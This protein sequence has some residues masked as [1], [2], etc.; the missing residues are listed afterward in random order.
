M[1]SLFG[2]SPAEILFARQKEQEQMQMLKNQQI[3][4]QGGQF[5]VFAPLYQAGLKF[6]DIGA[7]AMRQGLFPQQA[8]PALMKATAIQGV[9]S[10]YADQDTNSAEVLKKISADLRTIDPDA[11]LRALEIANK[12]KTEGGK[13]SLSTSDLEK[14]DPKDR[15]RAIQTYQTTGKLPEDISFIAKPEKEL[16]PS[17][18]IALAAGALGFEIPTDVKQF[19]TEQWTAIDRKI[20]QEQINKAAATAAKVNITDP[21]SKFRAVSEINSQTKDLDTQLV[22]LEQ[23]ISTSVNNR[24]PFAQKGF[25][26]LVGNVFGG[27][28][29][30]QE[31]I[32]RLRNSGTLGQRVENTL[33]L[34]AKGEIGKATVDDQLEVLLALREVA[35]QQRDNI[36][37]PYRAILKEEANSVAPLTKDRFKLPPLTENKQYI[38]MSVVQQYGLEKG[39]QFKTGGKTYIYNG[40]GTISPFGNQ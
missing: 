10:K 3:G 5:G 17:Q 8:D 23:A 15:P 39:Q 18:E 11:S 21:A 36:L 1:A 24:S 14:I 26:V 29:R 4:Q 12:L 2:P 34:F 30:A 33:G 31:E 13:I 27:K 20:K 40:N 19:S 22:N 7:S 6:G 16:P 9:L 28:A 35:G 37:T 32:N 25:E 38:P